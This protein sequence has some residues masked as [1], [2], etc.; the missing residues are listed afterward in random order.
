MDQS[1]APH[2]AGQFPEHKASLHL[3]HNDHKAYYQT[4]QQSV[5]A[6]DHGYTDDC[7]ISEEEKQKAIEANDCWILQWYPETPVGFCL[8]TAH[9]LD[10]LLRRARG[11]ETPT[12]VPP[13]RSSIASLLSLV[14][15]EVIPALEATG[16]NV[17]LAADVK[18][19]LAEAQTPIGVRCTGC[20]STWS[21]DELAELRRKKPSII[22]C[23]P[24]RNVVPVDGETPAPVP[25]VLPPVVTGQM[26]IEPDV[27][28]AEL[29][30]NAEPE[31]DDACPACGG[32]GRM[33]PFFP[34]GLSTICGN[35]SD[36]SPVSREVVGE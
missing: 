4:V 35:C 29:G 28:A 11:G 10:A 3:T 36:S 34:G 13:V 7:W 24:E 33:G 17:S 30:A 12:P 9:S 16:C 32:T 25:H 15:N 6:G 26:E 20:G 22:A 2:L 19:A 18:R 31:E 1:R 14:S 21:D 23:C 8:M 5:E 27:T